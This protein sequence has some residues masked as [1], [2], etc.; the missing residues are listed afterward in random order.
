MKMLHWFLVSLYGLTLAGC[1]SH[2]VPDSQTPNLVLSDH[3]Q[4]VVDQNGTFYP[5]DWENMYGPPNLTGAYSLRALAKSKNELDRLVLAEEKVIGE[6]GSY[7]SQK[8]RVF[9]LVHGYNNGIEISRKNYQKIR[10]LLE[11]EENDGIVEFHWD[12]LV[13]RTSIFG[14]TKIWFNAAGYSQLGGAEGLRDILNSMHEKDIYI[15]THSRGA[16]VALS[17]LSNPPYH[18][19][20]AKETLDF[21]GVNIESTPLINN[22]NRINLLLLAPAVDLVDF[23]VPD[24]Y[25]NNLEFRKLGEQ[26]VS[27]R[28]T[29]NPHDPTLR[30]FVRKAKLDN[31]F[32][33]T[34]LGYR[35]SIGKALNKEY[36]I[37]EE[38]F[39]EPDMH[40]HS[41]SD[42]IGHDTFRA[43]LNDSGI[44]HK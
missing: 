29:V 31:N 21:H 2:N 39:V 28:Y 25:E 12:G 20:F 24:Y 35:R 10:D 37:M 34:G 42:Y 8:D 3:S 38:Y 9:I 5:D 17:A 4:V 43:M 36:Q 23:K 15:I 18:P 40:S 44:S 1:A 27:I 11:V 13:S 19:R 6:I 41:F 33:P 30:K 16:S 32:N 14:A 22:K 26:L 7:L